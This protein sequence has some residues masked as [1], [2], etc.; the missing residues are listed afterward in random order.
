MSE[1][2]HAYLL[3]A[4][5]MNACSD[6]ISQIAQERKGLMAQL[7]EDVR[8]RSWPWPK[9]RAEKAKRE[10]LKH[11]GLEIVTALRADEELELDNLMSMSAA[12]HFDDPGMRIYVSMGD[13]RLIEPFYSIGG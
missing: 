11:G 4:K 6:A 3:A 9:R 8:E 12:A 5:V 7:V 13:F 1:S 10:V 2:S